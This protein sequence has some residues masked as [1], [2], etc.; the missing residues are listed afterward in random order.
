MKDKEAKEGSRKPLEWSGESGW[1]CTKLKLTLAWA[2]REEVPGL[3]K[4]I[5]V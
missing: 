1:R 4:I 3:G 2:W 5:P